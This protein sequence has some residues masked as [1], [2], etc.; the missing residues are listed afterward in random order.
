M[1]KRDLKL[2]ILVGSQFLRDGNV[3][4]T[5]FLFKRLSFRDGFRQESYF[6]IKL[7]H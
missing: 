7:F 4:I 5:I 6:F 3:K 1:K 2:R